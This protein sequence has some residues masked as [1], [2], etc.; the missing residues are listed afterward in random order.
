MPFKPGVVSNPVGR[1]RG[2]KDKLK[3]PTVIATLIAN[4]VNPA[5]KLLEM[6]PTATR[7]QQIDI[8]KFLVT[9]SVHKPKEEA[10]SVGGVVL[11]EDEERQ[12][13]DEELLAR[14]NTI[15]IESI[16]YP[17]PKVEGGDT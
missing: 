10:A 16:P 2:S 5:Q 4:S 11:D 7:D 9:Y 14:V 15:S 6:L 3:M 12:L 8:L 1:P 17:P 13:S